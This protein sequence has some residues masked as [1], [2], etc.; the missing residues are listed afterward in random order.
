M[1]VIVLTVPA[2]SP[3]ARN[4]LSGLF[5]AGGTSYGGGAARSGG[6]AGSAGEDKVMS[7]QAGSQ[8]APS[9][10][11]EAV[12][13]SASGGQADFPESGGSEAATA[14]FAE[15][16]TLREARVRAGADRPLLLPETPVAGRPDEVYDAKMS[17]GS[18]LGF[19]YRA[20]PGLPP[21][22]NTGIGIVLTETPGDLGATYLR[23]IPGNRTLEEVEV[24][25]DPGYWIREARLDPL[26]S[27]LT[28]SGRTGRPQA[29]VLLW[30]RDGLALRLE[31]N[32]TR[33]EAMRIAESV[34]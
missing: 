34:R 5:V 16:I 8:D 25:G 30:N 22:G 31:S 32:L 11:E 27:G 17:Y 23:D 6:E 28:A 2:L 4:A 9:A 14:S 1:V 13:E 29:G 7:G 21:V 33:E 19:V 15:R 18:A 10:A 3:N 12:P 26:T 20:R 24:G